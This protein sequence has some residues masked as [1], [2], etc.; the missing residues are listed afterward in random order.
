[1][2]LIDSMMCP[3]YIYKLSCAVMSTLNPET[4]QKVLEH[5]WSLLSGQEQRLG[6]DVY[7]QYI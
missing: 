1:M 7:D 2:S 6:P 3:E 4:G 5:K